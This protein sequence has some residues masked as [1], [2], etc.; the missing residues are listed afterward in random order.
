M[1]Q[2]QS[3]LNDKISASEMTLFSQAEPITSEEAERL[4]F[5]L[6]IFIGI[7]ILNWF[8]FL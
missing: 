8:N 3:T 5:L 1:V 6:G 2:S 4:R 7:H